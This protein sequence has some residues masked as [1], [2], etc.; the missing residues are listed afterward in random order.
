M[1]S[2]SHFCNVILIRRIIF[3]FPLGQN[4]RHRPH[5]FPCRR[6]LAIHMINSSIF[7]KSAGR[8]HRCLQ[9]NNKVFCQSH[10][11]EMQII[12]IGGSGGVLYPDSWHY[13][14]CEYCINSDVVEC[15]LPLMC[16]CMYKIIKPF[17]LFLSL[18]LLSECSYTS[19]GFT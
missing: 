5:S 8:I 13:Y 3:I 15:D 11:K 14:G 18:S 17:L 2:A 4:H 1:P 19:L 6:Q 10:C 12:S 16:M 7:E 9:D